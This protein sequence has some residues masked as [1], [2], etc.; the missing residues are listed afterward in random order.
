MQF[1]QDSDIFILLFL[2]YFRGV[3]ISV[4]MHALGVSVIVKMVFLVSQ[5]G[6]SDSE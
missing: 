4:G 3:I 2:V 1:E 5:V 6:K